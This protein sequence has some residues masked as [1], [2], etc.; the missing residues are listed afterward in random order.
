MKPNLHHLI[1][2]CGLAIA[3]P[4]FG[5]DAKPEAKKEIRVITST[6]VDH[7]AS[8]ERRVIR[9][10]G[11]DKL[12]E[13]QR[14]GEK[15]MV[16]FLGVE[17]APA[18]PTLAA[19]LGL[20]KDS[21]LVVDQIVPDSPAAAA[22]KQHDVLLKLDDQLLIDPRQFSVLIRQHKEG[23]EVTLTY[24]RAG[25]QTTAKVKLGKHE[26]PKFA[27]GPMMGAGAMSPGQVDVMIN[28]AGAFPEAGREET[29]RVLALI[30]SG[31]GAP[32]AGP[33]AIPPAMHFHG[34][35]GPGFRSIN[36]NAGNSNMVYSDD[37]GSIDVTIKDG[38]KTVV[39]K[40]DKGEQIFSGPV[41]TPEQHQALPP[42]VRERLGKLEGMQEFS[43]KTDGDFK[44]PD[45]RVIRPP[46]QGISS[47][48]PSRPVRSG[49]FF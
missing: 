13:L 43:F 8:G 49:Q 19:Q 31:H 29:D 5:Q 45:I 38:K 18:N 21:G 24:L 36:V 17:T 1:P 9:H 10:S 14:L 48:A 26:V 11:L 25:K 12:G 15:E 16:A 23:D 28:R 39:A 33:G 7:G 47:P 27:A 3:L 4:A 30:Q 37:Q 42:A 32:D 2:L 35:T 6:D 41:D 34:M 44:G 46:G 22:L 20:P 40:N